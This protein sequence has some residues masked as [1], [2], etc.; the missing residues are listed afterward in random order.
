MTVTPRGNKGK[1]MEPTSQHPN[2][3]AASGPGNTYS[4][5]LEYIDRYWPRIVVEPHPDDGKTIGLPC[6][7]TVPAEGQILRGLF[8]WD[9]FF[10][11]IGV[12]GTKRETLLVDI[13]ANMMHLIDRF[14]MIPNANEFYFLSHSQPPLST[15]TFRRAI[16]VK[17]RLG[18]L[19]TIAFLER[20]LVLAEKEHE[21]VWLGKE[22]PH[23]R[24]VHV[25]LSHYFD[26]NYVHELAGYESSWREV[27]MAYM[28]ERL[29]LSDRAAK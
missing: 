14:G 11:A 23:I 17:E 13:T 25:G 19:D 29:G 10:H 26:L 2:G 8:Y 27:D 7:Y 5:A 3:N 28:A 21:T 12:D 18:H 4:K 9:S 16:G 15:A 24:R 1:T 6:R 20:A 22:F